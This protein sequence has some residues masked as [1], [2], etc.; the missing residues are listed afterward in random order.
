ML[1]F[2]PAKVNLFFRVLR[3]R[4]DG[5]HEIASLYQAIDLGDTLLVK[6]SEI[7]ELSCSH[8]S[9][10]TDESNLVL[11]AVRLFRHKTALPVYAKIDLHK[12]I[13]MEAGLGGG[14]S[15][16]ATTLWA[17]NV[18]TGSPA[19]LRELAEWSGELGSDISFFFSTGTAYC[20]GRGEQF[21]TLQE[22]SFSEKLWIAKPSYGLSTPVVYKACTPSLFPS[23][24]PRQVLTQ[25][26][27]G[28]CSYFNDLEIPAF[29]LM[30]QLET[31][32][33]E[34][35]SLGFSSVTMTGSGTAFFCFGPPTLKPQLPSIKFYETKPISRRGHQ[36]YC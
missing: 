23:R 34:L 25:L 27:E 11:R 22:L 36:W 15:N 10:P 6:L 24:D 13:P 12:Q 20:T 30:P 21:Q 7:D 35:L 2:S 18:L 4:D 28:K 9:L 3:K 5:Y 17:L 14:S 32:K 19:S 1:F 33:Q 26:L 29:Q 16:A 8:P 31:L